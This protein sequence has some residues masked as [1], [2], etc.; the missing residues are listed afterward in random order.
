MKKVF[1]FVVSTVFIFLV[2]GGFMEATNKAVKTDVHITCDSS[3]VINSMNEKSVVLDSAQV[4][5]LNY[6][7]PIQ[8]NLNQ[9][10]PVTPSAI[11]KW[12][13]SVLGGFI[14]T[15]ILAWLHKKFPQWFPS[16]DKSVYK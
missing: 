8:I 10:D 16:A 6:Q 12:L 7:L 11:V 9:E 5:F 3:K 2:G 1:M 4:S 15:F 13:F 14:T